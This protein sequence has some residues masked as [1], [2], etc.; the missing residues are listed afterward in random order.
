M[1]FLRVLELKAIDLPNVEKKGTSDPY[2]SL[3]YQG[4]VYGFSEV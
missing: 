4:E 2:V 3:E 1:S